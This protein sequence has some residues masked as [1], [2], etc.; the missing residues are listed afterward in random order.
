MR[1][2]PFRSCLVACATLLMLSPVNVAAAPKESVLQSLQLSTTKKKKEKEKTTL[3]KRGPTVAVPK[4]LDRVPKPR[5]ERPRP[6]ISDPHRP[7][8]P[9]L[10]SFPLPGPE[11]ERYLTSLPH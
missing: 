11:R 2:S 6:E 9:P 1:H 10:V 8:I 5:P 7:R 3:P 4:P